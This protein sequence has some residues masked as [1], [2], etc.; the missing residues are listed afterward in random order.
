MPSLAGS[1]DPAFI[2]RS[3]GSSSLLITSTFGGTRSPAIESGGTNAHGDAFFLPPNTLAASTNMRA[4]PRSA[5][6]DSEV[7]SKSLNERGAH[8]GLPGSVMIASNAVWTETEAAATAPTSRGGARRP[9]KPL[10]ASNPMTTATRTTTVR[11]CRP[12]FDTGVYLPNC[13]Q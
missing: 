3:T 9:R 4:V 11:A 2:W 10:R 13:F 8:N 12:S 5:T 6:A 1:K 7:S